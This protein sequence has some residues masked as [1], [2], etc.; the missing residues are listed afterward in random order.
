MLKQ[1]L[2][3][4]FV[5]F[6][7][8]GL[9]SCTPPP[10]PKTYSSPPPPLP[11]EPAE[12]LVYN[13]K[14]T[15]PEAPAEKSGI[16]IGVVGGDWGKKPLTLGQSPFSPVPLSMSQE[17][18]ST[19]TPQMTNQDAKTVPVIMNV[20]KEFDLAV[21][22]EYEAMMI[23]RGF[24]TMGFQSLNDMTYPQKQ[25]CNLL[26]FPEFILS[27][28]SE[29]IG[30]QSSGDANISYKATISGDIILNMIEPLSGQ[31][32]WMKRIP[33]KPESFNFK[34]ITNNI[35]RIIYGDDADNRPQRLAGA[36]SKFFT[37]IMQTS[38][39]YFSPEEIEVMKKHSDDIRRLKR[40]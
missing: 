23:R 2:L 20:L 25:T 13:F 30:N 6:L 34:R 29:S 40:Y 24:N 4:L 33:L 11:K 17:F 27:I 15:Y 3:R 10:S 26:L 37:Q 36:L 31:K 16:T 12:A 21:K 14:F 22:K 9:A 39:N 32:V 5:G 35:D 28:N 38:W 8:L 19:Q 18:V 7:F 1:T